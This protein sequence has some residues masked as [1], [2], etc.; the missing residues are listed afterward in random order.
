MRR[1]VRLL[2]CTPESG[3]AGRHAHARRAQPNVRSKELAQND[4]VAIG[5]LGHLGGTARLRSPPIEVHANDRGVGERPL[6]SPADP[7]LSSAIPVIKC[8]V[9][10]EKEAHSL[11][12]MSELAGQV[13]H[14][15][16]ERVA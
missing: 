3:W 11:D 12:P 9:T 4:D 6:A 2:H 15:L 7:S 13:A 10:F 1:H 5:E 14:E 16:V 8:A